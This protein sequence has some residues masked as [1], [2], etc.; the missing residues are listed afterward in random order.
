MITW[1]F[2]RGASALNI[3]SETHNSIFQIRS[4]RGIYWN[5]ARP[6]RTATPPTAEP[7]TLAARLTLRIGGILLLLHVAGLPPTD[8]FTAR[9]NPWPTHWTTAI[10]TATSRAILHLSCGQL[11]LYTVQLPANFPLP[12]VRLDATGSATT[13]ARI[14]AMRAKSSTANSVKW[15]TVTST[16]RH[17]Q[18]K[19]MIVDSGCTFHLHNEAND[20]INVRACDDTISGLSDSSVSCSVIGDLPIAVKAHDGKMHYFLIPNVRIANQPDSLLSVQQLWDD[21]RIDCAFRDTN[22]LTIQST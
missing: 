9:I 3:P 14:R 10:K 13:T 5:T 16:G 11:T 12:G 22:A 2:Q 20:L 6:R 4:C 1:Y 7:N 8:Q 21:L 17:G 19:R 18:R 15:S